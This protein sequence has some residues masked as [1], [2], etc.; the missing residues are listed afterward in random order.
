MGNDGNTL[1]EQTNRFLQILQSEVQN[2]IVNIR[3]G[4]KTCER[5][6]QE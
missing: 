5:S 4:N 2:R 3:G 1:I 6:C